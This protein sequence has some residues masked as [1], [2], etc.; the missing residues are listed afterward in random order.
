MAIDK[1]QLASIIANKARKLCSLEGDKMIS[2]ITSQRNG[3]T[4]VNNQSYD[5][6]PENNE[7]YVNESYEATNIDDITYTDED[8][9][10]SKLPDFIKK[11]F[12]EQRINATGNISVLDGMAVKKIV[13][14]KKQVISEHITQPNIVT[15]SIDYTIIKAI[16]NECLK[17]YFEKQNINESTNLKTIALKEGT[18]SLVDNKGNIY[19]AKLEKIGN[20]K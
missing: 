10:N 20:K 3:K 11:S 12:T 9:E 13:P 15:N 14:Q 1:N 17:E 19:K 8:I 6:Y 2:E 18:I 4:L 7:S 16:V 5:T